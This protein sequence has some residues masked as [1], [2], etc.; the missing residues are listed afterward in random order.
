VRFRLSDHHHQSE[1]RDVQ[2]NGDHVGRN[3]TVDPLLDLMERRFQ[4][5]TRFRDFVGGNA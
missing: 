5:A 4:A 1:P 2:T 3:G